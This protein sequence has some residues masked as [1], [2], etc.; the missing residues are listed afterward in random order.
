MELC[1]RNDVFIAVASWLPRSCSI[2]GQELC[3]ENGFTGKI[4]MMVSVVM[5]EAVKVVLNLMMMM[6][7]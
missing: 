3:G 5:K 6:V 7:T 1:I 4:E 2:L